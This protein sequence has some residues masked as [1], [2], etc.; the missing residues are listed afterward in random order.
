LLVAFII[1]VHVF[2]P[3]TSVEHKMTRME[4]CLCFTHSLRQ[5]QK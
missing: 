1:T 5:H 4:H 2:D 3:S